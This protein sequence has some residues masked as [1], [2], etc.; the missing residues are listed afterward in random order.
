MR[1]SKKA[2][3]ALRALF[4][5]VEHYGGDPIPIRELAR[6]NDV[7]KKFLEQIMLAMKAQGWVESNAG[8]RGGYV[9]ARDPRRI[10]MGEVVRHFDGMLALRGDKT[11]D[12]AFVRLCS[13]CRIVGCVRRATHVPSRK[14]VPRCLE[15][16]WNDVRPKHAEGRGFKV[17]LVYILG[18]VKRAGV[19]GSARGDAPAGQGF[20]APDLS[21]PLLVG[22]A[23]DVPQDHDVERVQ[24]LDGILDHAEFGARKP[25][26][27]ARFSK[28]L[29]S[30]VSPSA[31]NA[32]DGPLCHGGAKVV[33]HRWP[34]FLG[35]GVDVRRR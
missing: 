3:Y 30:G 6:R 29:T 26:F 23:V 12:P 24:W 13:S 31:Q 34:Q 25:G 2:D 28:T 22:H 11:F 16:A 14:A 27:R 32:S 1:L 15:D 5:L 8:A 19:G 17:D 9:L 18:C 4:T 7:P 33:V 35:M 10:T 20:S 21:F